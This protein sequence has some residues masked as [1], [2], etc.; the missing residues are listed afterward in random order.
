MQK[1]ISHDVKCT[2]SYLYRN[3]YK[4]T[5]THTYITNNTPTYITSRN[6]PTN[7]QV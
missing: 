1:G 2:Y 3:P 4:L 5:D 7:D 6:I